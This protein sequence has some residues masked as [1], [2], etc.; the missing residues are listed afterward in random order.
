MA[1]VGSV[2]SVGSVTVPKTCTTKSIDQIL[3]V[4]LPTRPRQRNRRILDLARGLR[5][6]AGLQDL[7]FRDLRPIVKRWH[8]AA[9]PFV[10]TRD[11]DETWA[12]FI[13]AWPRVRLPLSGGLDAAWQYAQSAPL[14]SA[15]ADYDNPLVRQLVALCHALKDSTEGKFFLSTHGAARLLGALPMQVLRWLRMLEVDGI[16]KLLLRGDPVVRRAGRYK[17]TG[18]TP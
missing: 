16:I 9:L 2:G 12:D 3:E 13:R 8:V 5:F 15:A 4:T 6:D 10:A 14:P 7:A 1:Y 11:F 18:G 17:W